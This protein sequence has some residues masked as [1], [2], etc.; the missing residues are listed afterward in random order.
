[1]GMALRQLDPVPRLS[2]CGEAKTS[3]ANSLPT[4]AFGAHPAHRL[5]VMAGI[6]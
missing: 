4:F 1:M 2:L 5:S 3:N 6:V